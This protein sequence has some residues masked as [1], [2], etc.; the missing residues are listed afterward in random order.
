MSLERFGALKPRSKIVESA[1]SVGMR[2]WDRVPQR[3][4]LSSSDLGGSKNSRA[5]INASMRVMFCC[6]NHLKTLSRNVLPQLIRMVLSVCAGTGVKSL[7][8]EEQGASLGWLLDEG[9]I[10]F[11][12][13]SP[14][15]PV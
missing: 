10:H 11:R 3:T 6:R 8:V 9:R 14:K 2:V 5:R 7:F 12:F 4:Q 13:S 1:V 15:D